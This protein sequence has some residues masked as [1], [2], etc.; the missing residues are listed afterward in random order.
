MRVIF[1]LI[2]NMSGSLI[3]KLYWVFRASQIKFGKRISLSWPLLVEGKGKISFGDHATLEKNVKLGAG[4]GSRLEFGNK[5][6]LQAG[7]SIYLSPNVR[8]IFGNNSRIET[9]SRCFFFN[10]VKISDNVIIASH[11][12]IFSR[13]SIGR[14]ILTI[15]SGTNIGDYTIIDLASDVSIGENVAI[16]PRVIIYTHDHNYA[17][18]GITVPWKGKPHLNPVIIRNGAWI[19]ANVTILPGVE[20]GENAIVAAGSVLTKS[21]AGNTI[22]AGVPAKLIKQEVFTIPE[23]V[24]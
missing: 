8:F 23:N 1:A 18:E 24:G 10:D 21:I 15:G 7:V 3:R 12:Q 5:V 22:W 4:M 9:Q 16:G 14:G 6:N 13:E 2:R 19:G 11:C 20:V 17:E